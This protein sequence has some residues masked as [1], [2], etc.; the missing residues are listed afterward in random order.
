MI[1][2]FYCNIDKSNIAKVAFFAN[3]PKSSEKYKKIYHFLGG[4]DTFGNFLEAGFQSHPLV[5]F[6]A[7]TFF[8]AP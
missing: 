1:Y 4:Q 6:C 8:K 3:D 2:N 7:P 5:N